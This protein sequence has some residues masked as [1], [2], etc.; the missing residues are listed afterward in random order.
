MNRTFQDNLDREHSVLGP[1]DAVEPDMLYQC[2]NC[3]IGIPSR[4]ANQHANKKA[5]NDSKWL[6]II[7]SIL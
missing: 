3:F 6:E 5:N 1:S 7:D 4:G 2:T